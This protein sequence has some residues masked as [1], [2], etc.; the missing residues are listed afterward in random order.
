MTRGASTRWWVS[1]Y[2]SGPFEYHGPWWIT[3]QE[4]GGA[5]RRTICGAVLAPS[6][7]DAKAVIYAAHDEPRPTIVDWRFTD[8][9]DADWVPFGERFPRAD[10]M[11]WP[12][13]GGATS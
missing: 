8:P 5:A 10:W 3:G 6:A 7:D 2:S 13:P 4:I 11:R 12:D 9:R 1:W